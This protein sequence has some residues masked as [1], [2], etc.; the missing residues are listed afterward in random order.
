MVTYEDI[1]AKIKLS[2]GYVSLLKNYNAEELKVIGEMRNKNL[3]FP[4]M[5]RYSDTMFLSGVRI[6]KDNPALYAKG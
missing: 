1:Y 3:L 4:A 5:I 2:N 6:A